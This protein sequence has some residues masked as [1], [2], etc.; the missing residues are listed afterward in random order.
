MDIK[1]LEGLPMTLSVVEAGKLFFGIGSDSSYK[2]A[3]T[4]ELP[5]IKF[6][7]LLRVPTAACMEM[8]R[9][10]QRPKGAKTSD[11]SGAA[12]DHLLLE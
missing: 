5:T 3:K 11:T 1:G 2:A 7:K 4:G 9:T 8:L 6:G 12:P 10:G